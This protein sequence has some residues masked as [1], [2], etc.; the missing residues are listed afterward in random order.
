MLETIVAYATPPGLSGVAVL[1]LSGKD[2]LKI[3]EK[4]FTAGPLPK[5]AKP[6]YK[7]DG[8]ERKLANLSGYQA[9]LG[10]VHRAG[11]SAVIDQAI[12]TRFVAPHSYTGE[13]VFELSIHGGGGVRRKLLEACL[14]AGAR[15]AEP[16]E[17]TKRAFINGKID[18]AQSEAVMDLIEAEAGQA[19][20]VA[21][22]QLQGS[23]STQIHSYIDLLYGLLSTLEVGIEYP[24]YED[25][26]LEAMELEVTLPKLD[27][28]LQKL[29]AS[30]DQGRIL[31]EGLR[32]VIAGRPNVGKSSL[33]NYLSGEDRSIVT[34]YAGTTRDTV[35][36]ELN[37]GGLPVRLIDTAG[38]RNSED[39]VEQIGIERAAKAMFNSDLV[40]WLLDGEYLSSRLPD[41]LLKDDALL[42]HSEQEQIRA[43]G[44]SSK[45]FFV[46]TKEDLHAWSAEQL[47]LIEERL[48]EYAGSSAGL[49]SVSSKNGSG[50]HELRHR[51][52][53][54]YEAMG[55]VTADQTLITSQRHL[56][57]IRRARAI[58]GP[59]AESVKETEEVLVAQ[60]L[61]ATAEA[62]SIITGESV[63]EYLINDIFSRFCVGK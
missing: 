7:A 14:E 1:R 6:S 46:L 57:A 44:Q 3:T 26:G 51:I 2:S 59:L 9:A 19:S 41:G 15:P 54:H 55:A 12:V 27:K 40:F 32:V 38:L 28:E 18:L 62:L 22:R 5:A 45:L 17:F 30:F 25:S 61:K 33:L 24:E 43:V 53:S 52:V 36:I 37:I 63:S 11:D 42:S 4:I 50:I 56:D 35:D 58:L 16:G 47:A 29:E 21:V 34:A 8:R 20:E 31:K 49:I 10:W 13:D 60:Q 39:P 48:R 23:L